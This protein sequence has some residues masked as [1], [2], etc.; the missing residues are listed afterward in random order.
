MPAARPSIGPRSDSNHTKDKPP[1]NRRSLF[2]PS[3]DTNT[4]DETHSD[5]M[6]KEKD[7]ADTSHRTSTHS[8]ASLHEE[9][10]VDS[11]I[12]TEER[13][14]AL[15]ALPARRRSI[16]EHMEAKYEEN[17]GNACVCCKIL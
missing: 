4:L 16:V 3:K 15:P 9:P 7:G 5:I 14:T 11:P 1:S 17:G 2:D 6:V 13:K 8:D 12:V 10:L